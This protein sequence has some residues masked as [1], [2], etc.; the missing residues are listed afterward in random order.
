MGKSREEDLQRQK[1]VK[2]HKVKICTVDPSQPLHGQNCE[3]FLDG[4][5]LENVTRLSIEILPL[6]IAR[7]NIEL[8]AAVEFDNRAE[9]GGNFG[10][11][12]EC[13]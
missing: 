12:E 8:H 1:I 10:M 2:I 9:V 5:L 7:V 4:K 13:E 11:D 6:E 3:I